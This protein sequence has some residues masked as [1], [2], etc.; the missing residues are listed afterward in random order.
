MLKVF[1]SCILTFIL[2]DS[3]SNRKSF[4][5]E[6]PY[7]NIQIFSKFKMILLAINTDENG[8]RKLQ[9]RDKKGNIMEEITI[10]N[11]P[12]VIN[13]WDKDTI[14]VRFFVTD[15]SLFKPWFL[16]NP[17]K[18]KKIGNYNISYTYQKNSGS[19]SSKTILVDSFKLENQLQQVLF[20]NKGQIIDSVLIKELIIYQDRFLNVKFNGELT[21][22]ITYLSPDDK[23]IKEF[24]IDVLCND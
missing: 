22:S 1:Y 2:L 11:E 18:P 21:K 9:L 12:F 24:L 5:F 20:Y 17:D 23:M 13:R 16:E 19:L 6:N 15:I 7:V 14:N 3:C 4:E 10:H 8:A